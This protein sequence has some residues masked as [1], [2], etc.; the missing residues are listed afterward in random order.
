MDVTASYLQ[1]GAAVSGTLALLF[2]WLHARHRDPGAAWFALTFALVCTVYALN[3][4]APTTTNMAHRGGVVLFALTLSCLAL[5]LIDYLGESL[6]HRARWRV[7]VLIGPILLSLIV[8][9]T[10]VTRTTAHAVAALLF[11]IMAA[12]V[13]RASLREPRG[14]HRLIVVALLLHPAMFASVQVLGVQV[15]NLRYVLLLPICMIGATLFAVSLTRTRQR[16]EEELLARQ[17]AQAALARLNETLES[18]VADRTAELQ[19]MVHGLESFNRNVSH[20]LRGPLGGIAAGAML[21]LE[22]LHQGDSTYVERWLRLIGKEAGALAELVRDMLALARVED[23]PLQRAPTE[24]QQCLDAAITQLHL[25][26]SPEVAVVSQGLPQAAVDAGLMRQVFVN[27]VGNASKF[28]RRTASPR[29][30]VGSERRN[31]ELVVFVRDNG[32]GFDASKAEQLFQPFRRLPGTAVEGNGV[33]LTI[34]RRIVERHGGR[35]WAESQ[36]G[37]GATF[38]FSVPA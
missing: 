32:A 4:R 34:V 8:T 18:Q 1:T 10:T 31:S 29:I 16:L 36:L 33:G 24:L 37:R 7:A 38:Y 3:L 28:T 12:M 15:Y 30:E 6:R 5:G 25:S 23:V 35:V 9:F 26:S 27:L 14:G 2:L 21:A 13:W 20:D 22:R 17:T 19:A 11:L